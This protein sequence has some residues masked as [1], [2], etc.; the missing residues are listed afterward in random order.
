MNIF[1]SDV[2]FRFHHHNGH[3]IAEFKDKR[4][5]DVS[6]I[7]DKRLLRNCLPD[8]RSA[9]FFDLVMFR[10]DNIQSVFHQ[11]VLKI[12]NTKKENNLHQTRAA[13]PIQENF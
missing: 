10:K 1:F 5:S 7:P 11:L 4:M 6:V 12:F 2:F 13:N 3:A 9:D 8:L